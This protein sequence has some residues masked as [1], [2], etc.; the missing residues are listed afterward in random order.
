MSMY[1]N[2]KRIIQ[3]LVLNRESYKRI[4]VDVRF[5]P[6]KIDMPRK[7]QN[8]KNNIKLGEQKERRPI[9]LNSILFKL[10]MT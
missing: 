6:T 3:A 1:Y 7:E 8:Q 10:G 4:F 9:S 5:N 2:D